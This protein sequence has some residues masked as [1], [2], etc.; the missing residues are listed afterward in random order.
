MAQ[1][2]EQDKNKTATQAPTSR[3]ESGKK[4]KIDG[5]VVKRDV[6]KLVIRDRSGS[7]I[8]VNVT[9]STKIEERKSNPFRSAKKYETGSLV[10]G[11][12]VEVEGRGDDSG[13]LVADKIRITETDFK[14][15]RSIET[16]VDPVETRVTSTEDRMSAAEQNAQRLSGQLDELAAVANTARGGAKAAQEAADAAMN[17]A[18]NAN[19]RVTQTNERVTAIDERVSS[20]DDYEAKNTISINFKVRSVALS[21][22][23][24]T[25]LD[26]LATQAKSEKGYVIQ[27]AGFASA[28]GSESLNRVL[29]ERRANAVVRYLMENHDVPQRRIITP[30]GYG[31]LKPAADNNTR[32]GRQQNRRV[33]VAILVSKG[34]TSPVSTGSSTG[35]PEA[36]R[37][38]TS[39]L[40]QQ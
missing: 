24:K 1:D 26:E 36:T 17:E 10:R 38:R 33:E 21:Q 4:Q 2:Q 37:Q 5:V 22:D 16:R 7:D 34:L 15:A 12:A 20:V 32:E 8:N 29:S 19:Q 28:D 25:A 31:E 40:P 18:K 14:V 6:D 9:S 39:N 35:T 3:V 30:F 13:A 23:A 11:L 27:V